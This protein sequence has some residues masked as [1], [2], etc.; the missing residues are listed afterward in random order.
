MN[1]LKNWQLS[2]TLVLFVLGI[3]LSVQFRTQQTLLDSLE[4]MKEEDL[5]AMWKNLN[6]K[7]AKL[8]QEIQLLNGQ[9][10]ELMEQSNLGK[11]TFANVQKDLDKLRLINGLL[12]AKGPG[13]TLT[14][15]GESAVL[16]VDLVDLVNELWAS[17]AE[18]IAINGHRIIATTS[19]AQVEDAYSFYNTV[20]G[21]RLYYPIVIEAIGDANTL[22][23]GLTFTGGIIDNL[24]SFSIYPQIEQKQ[25]L[26]IP[27]VKYPQRWQVAKIKENKEN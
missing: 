1:K 20:D 25:E 18:A 13:I 17:G 2:V 26:V 11:N 15:S 22:E 8:E 6:D 23:K 4:S 9:Y 10:R 27:A 19:I 14:I 16:A 21:E 24:N 3:F 5:V 7:R 12:P